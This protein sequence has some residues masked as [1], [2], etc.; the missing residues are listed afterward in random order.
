[1][2]KIEVEINISDNNFTDI[3]QIINH[4]KNNFKETIERENTYTII[5]IIGDYYVKTKDSTTK[6][7]RKGMYHLKTVE[8]SY[9]NENEIYYSLKGIKTN[10]EKIEVETFSTLLSTDVELIK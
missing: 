9:I 6:R 2:N 8:V 4:I 7:H 5:N 3:N 1:M 10:L